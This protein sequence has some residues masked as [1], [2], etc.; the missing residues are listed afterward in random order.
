MRPLIHV[1]T[2]KLEG[3][4]FVA[5]NLYD[6]NGRHADQTILPIKNEL[7]IIDVIIDA[8]NAHR[9]ATVDLETDNEEIFKLFIPMTGVNVSLAS[10]ADLSG[11]YRIL[12]PGSREFPMLQELYLTQTIEEEPVKAELTLWSRFLLWAKKL[13]KRGNEH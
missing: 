1:I 6:T 5:L 11:L 9:L 12:S 3:V 2:T 13:L 10:P 8:M 7:T 4:E